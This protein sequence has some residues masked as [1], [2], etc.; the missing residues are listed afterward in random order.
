MLHFSRRQGI[1]YKLDFSYTKF[2]FWSIKQ[3]FPAMSTSFR[4]IRQERSLLAECEILGVESEEG[5]IF[6][7][8]KPK[9]CKRSE[10][11]MQ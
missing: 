9:L 3:L 7:L 8:F 5:E 11:L 2:F 6:S 10:L 4:Q 1:P